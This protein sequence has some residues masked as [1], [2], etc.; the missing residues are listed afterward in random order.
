LCEESFGLLELVREALEALSMLPSQE[1]LER[2]RA[3]LGDWHRC[4]HDVKLTP[5]AEPEFVLRIG[6]EAL[7]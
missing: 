6:E 7:S 4:I 5:L 2:G 1:V 3:E